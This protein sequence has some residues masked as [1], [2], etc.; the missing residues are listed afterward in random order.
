MC[1]ELLIGLLLCLILLLLLLLLLLL[2]H[3]HIQIVVSL[4]EK[5]Y[6]TFLHILSHLSSTVFIS[7][8]S[9]C[10]ISSRTHVYVC[11]SVLY[12]CTSVN[13][14]AVSLYHLEVIAI[15]EGEN[16][17]VRSLDSGLPFRH[18]LSFVNITSL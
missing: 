3:T 6:S 2:P 8:L 14:S 10:L 4:L 12:A 5:R 13:L 1:V 18:C 9:V 7:C 15:D 16:Q 17:T 11:L